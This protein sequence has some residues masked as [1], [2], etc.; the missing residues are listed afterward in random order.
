MN[1]RIFVNLI[2]YDIRKG[3][4]EN[5]IKWIVGVFIF[6]FFSFIT[7]SDFSVNSPELGFLAYFT[8]ILQGMPP[9]IKT[10][11]S[12]FTIP[13]SWFCFMHFYFLW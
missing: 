2:L 3:F 6:V 11:D 10:D 9:Y 8:N 7:V 4:R 5:K 13:V 1:R 12:V